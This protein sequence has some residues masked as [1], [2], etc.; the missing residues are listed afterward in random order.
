MMTEDLQF[1]DPLTAAG[2]P[3]SELLLAAAEVADNLRNFAGAGGSSIPD[4]GATA[5]R[6]L[7]RDEIVFS[8]QPEIYPID[9]EEALKSVKMPLSVS[10]A[11][12]GAR[13]KYF[14]V[15]FPFDVQPA[16]PWNFN[17]LKVRIEFRAGEQE[18]RPKVQ[19]LFPEARFQDI[20]KTDA[21]LEIGLSPTL[22][23]GVKTGALSFEAAPVSASG[24]ASV[25]AHAKGH[26]AFALGPF[27]LNWKK[28]L[29]KT[30]HPGLEWVWWE[31]GGA[32]LRRG[33]SPP[34]MVVLQIPEAATHV[35]AVGQLQASRYYNLI[36]NAFTNITNWPQVYR[37]F[38]EAGAPYSP[39]P[40]T[41][42]LSEDIVR[43]S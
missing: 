42:D 26:G 2:V 24:D 14:L 8:A 29:V 27:T 39:A 15:K 36:R 5:L 11:D 6:E 3:R 19:A 33:D 4:E 28:A 18:R 31:V 40:M 38:V 16:G 34:F 1:Y 23:F 35:S 20:L 32:D 22:E 41:W 43:A 13:F 10:A 9:V 17:Q 12:Y 7:A 25:T 37:E 30:C 21:S